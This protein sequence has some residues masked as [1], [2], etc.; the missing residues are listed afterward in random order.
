MSPPVASTRRTAPLL[1]LFLLAPS[2]CFNQIGLTCPPDAPGCDEP[3]LAAP[4]PDLAAP[5]LMRS[6]PD[7]THL[8]DLWTCN[9][10][11]CPN[12][13]CDASLNKCFPIDAQH[14]A[15]A[16]GEQCNVCPP[17][18]DTCVL[19]SGCFC[20]KN[21]AC[22]AGQRCDKATCV[23]D[24]KSCPN[25]CCANSTYC[26]PGTAA[27]ACGTGGNA[28]DTC[29]LLEVCIN[30]KCAGI[31]CV[32]GQLFCPL[33]GAPQCGADCANCGNFAYQCQ[34]SSCVE[35]CKGC[36]GQTATCVPAMMGAPKLCA[37]DCNSCP[38]G[39]TCIP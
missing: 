18:T 36:Q 13:C 31:P 34:K 1:A 5:D 32:L 24:G 37:T 20:G 27:T 35:N 14:C 9:K 39:S 3:D 38:Q 12:G 11:T 33:N 25:G 4:I 28:C 6:R 17:T 22:N 8:P 2:G 29:K 19:G 23:C 16:G 26:L 15:K 30:N 21:A 10:E 7:L